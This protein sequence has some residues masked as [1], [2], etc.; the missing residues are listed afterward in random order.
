MATISFTRKIEVTE[1]QY[2][3]MLKAKPTKYF[4][5]AFKRYKENPI[6]FVENPEEIEKLKKVWK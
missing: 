5:E 2:K 3:K 4:Q 6:K 1:E